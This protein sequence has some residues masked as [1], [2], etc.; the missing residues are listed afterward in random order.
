MDTN[1]YDVVVCGGEL[2]GLIAA[3]LLARRGFRGLLL[4]HDAERPS[5]EAAGVMLSREPALLPPLDG[6]APGRGPA[7]GAGGGG[8]PACAGAP[9]GPR[10][11]PGPPPPPATNRSAGGGPASP[12]AIAR[13]WGARRRGGGRQVPPGPRCWPGRC[14]CP[15]MAS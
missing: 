6:A 1:F 11:G 4:G 2:T 9:G 15:P 14:P 10:P 12:G 5:F 7:A 3:T 13:P 8:R